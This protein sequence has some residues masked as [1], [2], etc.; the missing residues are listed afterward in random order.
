MLDRRADVDGLSLSPVLSVNFLMVPALNFSAVFQMRVGHLTAALRHA[1]PV[2]FR[3][4]R[5][6]RDLDLGALAFL[7]L[8]FVLVL[9]RAR[10]PVHP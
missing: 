3:I 2:W 6:E 9:L 4:N 8:A 10:F 1:L 7:P 5:D